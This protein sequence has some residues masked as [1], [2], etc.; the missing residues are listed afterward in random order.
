MAS[1][2]LAGVVLA[3]GIS[4]MAFAHSGTREEQEA[5]T[6]DV[7]QYCSAQIP[8]ESRIVAC[9]KRNLKKLSPNCR[10]VMTG[11]QLTRKTRPQ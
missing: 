9:L 4:T 6:P 3:G 2:A 11:G 1:L 5:C 7:F 10:V 8:D